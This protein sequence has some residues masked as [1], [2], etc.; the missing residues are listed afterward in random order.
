MRFDRR[1]S[2]GNGDLCAVGKLKDALGNINWGLLSRE[3]FHD[4]GRPHCI[5]VSLP[6]HF[7]D[8]L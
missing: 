3:S 8:S 2:P 5:S 6:K 7:Q 1:R 4:V